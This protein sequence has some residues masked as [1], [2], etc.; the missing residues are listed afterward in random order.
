MSDPYHI[1]AKR[2]RK[3]DG[4]RDFIKD[5][6]IPPVG[7]PSAYGKTF[8]ASVFVFNLLMYIFVS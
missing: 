7:M 2:K 8:F 5:V 3:A 6:K 1:E 4:L